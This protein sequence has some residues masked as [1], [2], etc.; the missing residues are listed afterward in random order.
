MK[1]PNC[2][3]ERPKGRPQ[4]LNDQMIR[5]L[6]SKGWSLGELAEKFEVSRG[7]IQFSLKRTENERRK[8]MTARK[9]T[10][11]RKK[12]SVTARRKTVAKKAKRRAA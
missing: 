3:F 4:K 11:S 12:A 8:S 6:R 2:G 7:A 9:K 10:V 5:V 1:C